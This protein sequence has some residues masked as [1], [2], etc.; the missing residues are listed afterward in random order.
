M[1]GKIF[2]I[3]LAGI[4]QYGVWISAAVVL[5]K[6][7]GPAM[8][9]PIPSSLSVTNMLF[10]LLFF[11][12]AFFLYSSLY[13]AIG[14][15]AEDEQHMGQ[16]G[17]P[18]IMCLIIPLIMVSSIVMNPNSQLITGLSY[19]PLT[20]PIVMLTRVLVDTPPP[21]EI[22]LSIGIT[23]FTIIFVIWGAAKIFRT[24]ILMTGKRFKI[25]EI[26]KWIKI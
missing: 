4:L 24:G 25:G 13:A 17:T 14:A 8:N 15:A 11:V 23:V 16:L 10:L 20:A 26:L 2:G 1:F 18:L 12:L 21:W 5:T 7:V 22:L 6:I 9:V 19:F 3:G